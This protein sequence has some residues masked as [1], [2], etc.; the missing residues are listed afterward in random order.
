MVQRI[1]GSRSKTRHK[2]SKNVRYRG[3]LSLTRYF[4]E[5][6]LGDKVYLVAEPSYHGG[7]YHLRFH[8]RAGIIMNKKGTCYEVK[9]QDMNMSKTLIVHPVHLKRS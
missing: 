2:M 4:Q 7:T 5:F 9:I 3:K 6:K 1:G 8:G